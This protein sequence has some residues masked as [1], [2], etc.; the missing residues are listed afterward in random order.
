VS[1]DCCEC[2]VLVSS[3]RWTIIQSIADD[4]VS[5]SIWLTGWETIDASAFKIIFPLD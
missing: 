1:G 2:A 3:G 4:K 5:G